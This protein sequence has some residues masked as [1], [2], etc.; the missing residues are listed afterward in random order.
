MP[1]RPIRVLFDGTP[2][3]GERTGVGRYTASLSEELASMPELVDARSVAFTMRGW[4]ELR[5]VLP[6]GVRS[7][8]FP[9]SARAARSSWRRG[10]S[11][12]QVEL[13]AGRAD[14]VHGT[15]FVLPGTA[16]AA[17]VLTIHDVAFLDAPEELSSADA[18]FPELVQVSAQRADAICTPTA[19]VADRVADRLDVDRG[20]ITVTPL[21][22][23][24][25]W[26]TALPP[27]NELRAKFGL[28]NEYLLFIGAAG[29]RKGLSWLAKAHANDPSLPPLVYIGPGPFSVNDRSQTTGYVSDVDLRHIVAGATALVLPSRDEGFGLPVLE[30]LACDVP[31]V[32]T[33]VP[34][35]REVAG[36]CAHLVPYGDAD[37][38]TAALGEAAADTGS[39]TT[40]LNRRTHAA[41]FT[42]RRCAELTVE[43]YRSVMG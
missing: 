9:V 7:R 13:F 14:V 39:T 34:T 30:A 27:N 38:L 42:W 10:S 6:H 33:D 43:T 29:P 1:D 3:I 37:A 41:S 5:R 8:G 24:P 20:K 4:R 21:G 22:V 28:P 15:N 16:R 32:C 40:S 17:G 26:F 23:D 36:D 12:P 18:H 11:F 19:V 25:S 31:V 35:L 2:L